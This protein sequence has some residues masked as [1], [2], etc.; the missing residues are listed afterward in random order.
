MMT[1]DLP[2]VVREHRH[3]FPDGFF[4]RLG[5]AFLTAFTRTYL[6]SPDGRAYVA[7]LNG[8]TVAFLVGV[9]NPVGHRRY[10]LRVHGVQ[11]AFRAACGLAIRP[12]LALHFLRTR[13]VRY[14]RRLLSRGGAPDPGPTAP[15]GLTAVLAHVAV[16]TEARSRGIGTVLV[17]RFVADAAYC[18]CAR[19][20]LVTL[21]G[22]DGAGPYYQ[23]LG[24]QPRGETRT[25]EGRSLT[26]YE[27]PLWQPD[28][29]AHPAPAPRPHQGKRP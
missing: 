10:L 25:P 16:A 28:P 12:R 9:T 3:H 11:L 14:S 7:E 15:G 8:Q 26:T 21:T 17:D 20:S 2:F 18:G 4:A 22:V 13:L 6:G 1:A 5:P 24:W 23:R 19:V 27:L 29:G